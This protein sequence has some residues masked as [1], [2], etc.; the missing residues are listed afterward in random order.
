M[1]RRRTVKSDLELAVILA[2]DPPVALADD[3]R[4]RVGGTRACL[5][6]PFRVVAEKCGPSRKNRR[7]NSHQ[8]QPHGGPTPYSPVHLRLLR[9]HNA[10]GTLDRLC[11]LGICSAITD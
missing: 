5:V 6:E 2:A 10:T 1:V 11:Y 3:E 8:G 7:H 9:L 4:A